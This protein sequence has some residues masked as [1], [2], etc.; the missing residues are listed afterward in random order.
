MFNGIREF[1]GVK[2]KFMVFIV[3][4]F[5]FYIKKK[6]RLKYGVKLMI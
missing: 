5:N 3:F 4:S 2:I 1:Q 6:K